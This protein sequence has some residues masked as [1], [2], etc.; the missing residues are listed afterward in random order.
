MINT[1]EGG[2][3]NLAAGTIDNA[4]TVYITG[5]PSIIGGGALTNSYALCVDSGATKFA[6]SIS[7]SD[8][9]P[10]TSPVTG[11]FL[12]AGGIGISNITNA[13]SSSN[14]GTITT[15]G[16]IAIAQ[17]LYIG[18]KVDI[19][20]VGITLNH[21]TG[22]GINFRSRDRT[23]T[24]SN[25]GNLMFNTFEGGN[26]NT[27][28][29]L[30]EASTV[31][32][33]T[34]PII[35]GGGGSITDTYA[36][37]INS[38]A[39]RLDDKLILTDTISSTSNTTGTLLNS[40]GIG[41]SLT[42]DAINED[43]GG[44]ITTAGGVG[45]K[46]KLFVGNEITSNNGTNNS[47]Y[48]LFTNGLS[49]FTLD[50]ANIETGSNIGSDFVLSR[51]SDTGTLLGSIYT[52]KRS[53]GDITINTNTV[54]T[55]NNTGSV[56]LTGGLAISNTTNA[57]SAING[58]TITT[59]GGVGI[60]QDLYV[61]SNSYITG[62]FDVD[63]ITTLDQT[64]IN[65]DDGIFNV[66]GSNSINMIVGNT[67]VFRTTSGSLTLDS[68]SGTIIIEGD[69]GITIDSNNGI[70]IDASAASNI[71][72]SSGIMTVSGE[73]VNINGGTNEID[74]TTTGIIDLNSGT[75]GITIDSTDTTLGIKIG[76][77]SS[78]VPITIGHIN[79]E[80]TIGNNLTVNGDLTVLGTTTS[81][82]ST[83]VNIQD[84]VIVVN[85]A[86]TGIS[87]GGFMVRRYQIPNNSGLG[88]V[89]NVTAKETSS[90][91]AGSATP[92]TLVLN[93][94][95]NAVNDYYKGW[96]IKITSGAGSGQVRRIKAYN[97]ITKTAIIYVTADN[98]GDF[99]DGLDL[100]TAPS[101]TE[102]YEL[103]D[104][105]FVGMY[106][107]ESNNEIRLACVPYDI[108]INTFNTPTSYANLHVNNLVLEGSFTSSGDTTIDGRL[109]VDNTAI[110]TVIVRKDGDTGDVFI[111]DSTN[112]NIYL[113][114]PINTIGSDI[115]LLFQQRDSVNTTQTYS[116]INS[117]IQNN[118]S[119]NLRNDLTFSVQ[120]DISGLTTYMTLKGDVSG[121]GFVD[122]S[123]DVD[124][125]RILNTTASTSSTTG[126]FRVIGGIGIS[127][128]TDAI[129]SLNGGAVTI[130]GGLA[131]NK[132]IYGGSLLTLSDTTQV[133]DTDNTISG[134]EGTFNIQGDIV[135][136]NPTKNTIVFNGS[137]VSI[138]T[139]TNRSIGTKIV[140]SPNISGSTTD[141]A[142]G[143]ESNSLWYSV[144]QTSDSHKFYLA[145]TE[146][147]R[148]DNTGLQIRQAND[149]IHFYNG[150]NTSSIFESSNTLRIKPHTSSINEGI[151]FRDSSDLN[152]RIRI[153]SDGQLTLG[154]SNYS[155]TPSSSGS[156]LNIN[157]FTFT[158][159]N[160]SASGTT[161]IMTFNSISQPTLASVNTSV[162]TTDAINMYI[163]GAPI[164]GTNE[165]FTNAY[166]LYIAQGS[167]ISSSGT[168]TTASS[169]YIQGEPTGTT[170]TD[171][172]ALWVNSGSS[173]FDGKVIISDNTQVAT[174]DNTITNGDGSLNMNG[175]IILYNST[176]N[177][178]IYNQSG[179]AI[180][181]LTNRSIGSKLVLR[182]QVDPSN[183]DYALGIESSSLWYSVPSSSESH[184]FYL[185]TNERVTIDSTG[186]LLNNPG[187]TFIMR[188]NTSDTS[189]NKGI[190]IKGGG[191]G[192]ET[193]GAQIQVYG[194]ELNSGNAVISSGESGQIKLQSG[195]LID[196]LV[197][198]A[199]G[200]IN[201]TSIE[202]AT[203]TGTGSMRIDGGVS[204]DKS[205]FIG[206]DNG[207]ILA[208]DF[209]QRYDLSGDISGNLNIQSKTSSTSHSIRHFTN[210][211]DNTDN[212]TLDIY[213]LGTPSSTIN[214]E[215]IRIGFEPSTYTIKTQATGS[216]TVRE[217]NLETGSNTSQ[218]KL[219]TTGQV[220]LSSTENSTGTGTGAL[221]IDGGVSIDKSLFI[222]TDSSSL[223]ALDFDQ[224]YDFSGNASGN[225]NIQ[226]K[227][228]STTASYRYFTNDGDNTD[229]NILE[230]Y[231]FGTPSSTINS[232]YLS[233]G[234]EPTSYNIKTQA[235]GSG[236]IRELNLETGSNTSQIKLLTSGQVSFS[237]TEASTSPSTGSI[238][239]NG[240]LGISNTTD[241][242]SE[243]NGGALTIAGGAAVKKD[244]Y[245][246][247]DLHITGVICIGVSNPIIT[248]S[249]TSNVTGSVTTHSSRMIENG[250]ERDL[251][252]IFR[253]T[254]TTTGLTT[255]FEFTLPDAVN[256]NT[257]IYDIVAV[258]NGY[259]NDADPV[260]LENIICYAVTGD[261]KGKIKFTASGTD[262]HTIQIFC[263][264]N[265]EP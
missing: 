143:M 180:P 43:N 218:I 212:N 194:N 215:F 259:R 142:F 254:P 139:F 256:N 137:G 127:N 90:F 3:I 206:T 199:T 74:L 108:N 128:T 159:S 118:V 27:A 93:L 227:T 148:I 216:G 22:Q 117:I 12:L 53:S 264:Y 116:Q 207:S 210:D 226:S 156:L 228:P 85:S 165:N 91:Q 103:Y 160:T 138:P 237:S 87:D 179:S 86:P 115:T 244:L 197:I 59:A 188:M 208:L 242:I 241:A 201:I 50:L 119:G 18:S 171:S 181:S 252:V 169:L 47:H 144:S 251:S 173:R 36:L 96:W 162:T 205:L 243:D 158:D 105:P 157:T 29:I 64:T 84:N 229:N 225:L 76:V 9:T 146:Q 79:S 95:A 114:N 4:A 232:E 192:D 170:I 78:L 123:T 168:I 11:A 63:G 24:T 124:S 111:V 49:R 40:G 82:Q 19:G 107:S 101:A 184:K 202:D 6:G 166:G 80:V 14:G 13:V 52:I 38:G 155:G 153:N 161:S 102:T 23:I 198:L 104:C 183:V 231:G 236:T 140:L 88:E 112:G 21:L 245:V 42:T 71:S 126:A 234:F 196:R 58:G 221:R 17:D 135:L 222:G 147:I 70:S 203:G 182:P 177:T 141:Y 195:S 7:I 187:S 69:S 44:T 265:V 8:T 72:T 73:G 248:T 37:L 209:N 20:D 154:L 175:D 1:F 99:I 28:N 136:Y 57:V 89:V 55:N 131:V 193:R 235:T 176:K 41:I 15:A 260:N 230:I 110:D 92:D 174:N 224:R 253:C 204:I 250:H 255:T 100:V 133:G 106:Y 132:K 164:K 10:S 186:L 246:G 189:D 98:T 151:I 233:M 185:G 150:V 149:G 152:S 94:T 262:T 261:T 62:S 113:G 61:G 35:S 45:I 32:I 60:A 56:I 130:A 83:V 190:I 263:N 219:L 200:Q 258:C 178:I 163:N 122:F 257:N 51:Y 48:Q 211:G 134:T 33:S 81:L 31:Y 68:D 172:Y 191:D 16:G 249:S 239:L 39:T 213:G 238:R 109:I 67:S 129:S 247:G 97:G 77:N 167:N 66:S 54:S 220:S 26:I 121:S 217:L 240:G 30:T 65:T 223:L 214:S 5:A 145:T 120:K 75:G 2:T 34:A 125:V 46:K 25:S